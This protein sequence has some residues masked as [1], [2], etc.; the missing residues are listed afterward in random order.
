MMRFSWRVAL[1]FATLPG[2][3][4]VAQP[5]V[6]GG[7]IAGHVPQ[8]PPM[9]N[10]VGLPRD[11]A[12]AVLKNLGLRGR[13]TTVASGGSSGIVV[14]Q[15]IDRGA[16]YTRGQI[17]E[18]AVSSGSVPPQT[19]DVPR[20]PVADSVTV[21]DVQGQ[22][23]LAAAV[24]LAFAKLAVGRT[25][26]VR[27]PRRDGKV[28]D[29]RPGPGTRVPA[30]STVELTVG[31]AL[32]VKVPNLIAQSRDDAARL[33]SGAGLLLGSVQ[34]VATNQGRGLVSRQAPLP[35]ST[36]P[37]STAVDITV[38][39]SALVPTP[40]VTRLPLPRAR[41]LL[42]SA[43]LVAGP[44]DSTEAG[45]PV[46]LVLT[47]NPAAGRMVAPGSRVRLQVSTLSRV[48]HVPNL[49]DSS[50]RAA[51]R[52]LGDSGL[53]LG[54][55]DST[56]RAGAP[57]RILSQGPIADALVIRGS[58]VSVRIS[59]APTPGTAV[60]D[61]PP[62][63]SSP[64]PPRSGVRVPLLV[65]RTRAEA[66]RLVAAVGLRFGPVTTVP[67]GGTDT[68]LAQ[69]PRSGTTVD[70][71]SAVAVRVG[72]GTQPGDSVTVPDVRHVAA[73]V[74]ES[75]MRSGGLG[76]T[77]VDTTATSADA[78]RVVLQTPAPGARVAAGTTVRLAIG[79]WVW[80]RWLKVLATI[81]GLGAL[82]GAF[83]RFSK[84]HDRRLRKRMNFV[85]R[86]DPG[87]QEIPGNITPTGSP[88]LGLEARSDSGTQTVE[89]EEP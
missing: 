77:R 1:V 16:H 50:V 9:P 67:R 8:T 78:G 53:K 86:T 24:T 18:L 31:Q 38:E 80:P 89:G 64:P 41:H 40:D 79:V 76:V 22:D 72:G 33:L 10:L 88:A 34:V 58:S 30:H 83:H 56:P 60:V 84:R 4:Q 55:I 14:R 37:E 87:Q 12:L 15:S 65:G 21:P 81:F 61:T 69:D 7:A 52:M 74:A 45:P 62:S 46:D 28:V 51:A 75:V 26:T 29:Q 19:D 48:V 68:V 63:P 70:S 44:I 39:I 59:S 2:M 57:G 66:E 25:A 54:A 42:D 35:A 32:R 73:G 11:S 20:R 3:R 47:Q 43:G 49:R 36:V 82:A 13:L 5:P 27:D 23:R 17:V 85:I 71:S 6:P